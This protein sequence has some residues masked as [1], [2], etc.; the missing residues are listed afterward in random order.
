ML[1]SPMF[2]GRS[3][4]SPRSTRP[5]PPPSATYSS[6]PLR[7]TLGLRLSSLHPDRNSGGNRRVP[8]TLSPVAWLRF[9]MRTHAALKAKPFRIRTYAK[10][11]GGG[12][13][14]NRGIS[15]LKL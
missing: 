3:D 4:Y 11:G 15:H 8:P 14:K 13:R 1:C 7:A 5:F 2:F 9:A 10:G 12:G 6:S